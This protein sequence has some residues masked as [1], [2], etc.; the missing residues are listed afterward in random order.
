[1]YHHQIDVSSL[2]R[3]LKLKVGL[4]LEV[5]AGLHLVDVGARLNNGLCICLFVW[6]DMAHSFVVIGVGYGSYAGHKCTFLA[7][8]WAPLCTMATDLAQK[9]LAGCINRA[10]GGRSKPAG[11]KLSSTMV[12][13]QRRHFCS[14]RIRRWLSEITAL[15]GHP[16]SSVPI[17]IYY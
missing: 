6:W 4:H 15:Y 11:S 16:Q 10:S 12:V 14:R 5:D 1:M 2:L 3:K 8:V 9:I 13:Y 17:K 7:L